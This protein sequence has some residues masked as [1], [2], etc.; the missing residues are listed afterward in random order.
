MRLSDPEYVAQSADEQEQIESF[1][2]LL[3]GIWLATAIAYE[4]GQINER[5][6]RTYAADIGIKLRKW[7]GLRPHAIEIAGWYPE[8]SSYEMFKDICES[9]D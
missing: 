9:D 3:L 5:L 4:Q 6:Y 1:L 8:T 2:F 7:P